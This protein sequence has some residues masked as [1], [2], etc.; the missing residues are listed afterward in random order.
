MHV[1][2]NR[3]TARQTL[4]N[5]DRWHLGLTPLAKPAHPSRTKAHKA[6][7]KEPSQRCWCHEKAQLG[8]DL[9]VQVLPV[10]EWSADIIRGIVAPRRRRIRAVVSVVV[11]AVLLET[12]VLKLVPPI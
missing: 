1:L 6:E 4:Q 3:T 10:L 5:K 12:L 2:P 8:F 11:A 9:V 7:T